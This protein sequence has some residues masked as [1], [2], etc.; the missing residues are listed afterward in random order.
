MEAYMNEVQH[1]QIYYHL[2][3]DTQ[4]FENLFRTSKSKRNGQEG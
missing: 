3:L 2:A 4:L 1:R